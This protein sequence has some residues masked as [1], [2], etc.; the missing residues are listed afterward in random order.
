MQSGYLPNYIVSVI[1]FAHFSFLFFLIL[2]LFFS[3]VFSF[4]LFFFLFFF[5]FFFFLIPRKI[6]SPLLLCTTCRQCSAA[7][8]DEF[9]WPAAGTDRAEPKSREVNS[10]RL[11]PRVRAGRGRG[12]KRRGES[13][14]ERGIAATRARPTDRSLERAT[15]RTEGR[16]RA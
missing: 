12:D 4:F 15:E 1:R 14:K 8:T 3:F 11:P 16:S 6:K 7:N 9:F 13:V 10:W 2:S 5:F